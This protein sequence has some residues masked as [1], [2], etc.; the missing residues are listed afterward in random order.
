M[1][2]QMST[3]W[4]MTLVVVLAAL[5]MGRCSPTVVEIRGQL[6]PRRSVETLVVEQL[7]A[8]TGCSLGRWTL[9]PKDSQTFVVGSA[10]GSASATEHPGLE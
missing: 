3:R 10:N 9:A 7:S 6:P 8:H 4:P 2:R 5:A 1:I